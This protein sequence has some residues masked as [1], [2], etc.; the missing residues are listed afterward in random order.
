VRGFPPSPGDGEPTRSGAA[1]AVDDD[2]AGAEVLAWLPAMAEE[3]DFRTLASAAWAATC[4]TVTVARGLGAA[5]VTEDGTI[6][7]GAVFAAAGAA[8]DAGGLF[9]TAV[10]AVVVEATAEVG[11][12]PLLGT[13]AVIELEDAGC[14]NDALPRLSPAAALAATAV[15]GMTV[16]GAGTLTFCVVGAGG[17]GAGAAGVGGG[18]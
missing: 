3:N 10:E 4:W 8:G 6:V 17:V 1:A 15:A 7:A 5:I 13:A 16:A 9:V 12:L 18:A 2:D 14:A 11:V